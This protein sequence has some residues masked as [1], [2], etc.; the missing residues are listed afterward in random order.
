MTCESGQFRHSYEEADINGVTNPRYILKFEAEGYSPFV[1]RAIGADEGEVR[2]E[3][4]LKPATAQI[5]TVLQPDGNPAVDADI[6]LVMPGSQLN[7]VPG[8]FSREMAQSGGS[9]LR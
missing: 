6:G 5:V 7:L 1:S 3:V 9:L 8:G 2:L 4:A